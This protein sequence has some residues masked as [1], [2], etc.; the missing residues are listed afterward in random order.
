MDCISV[1]TLAKLMHRQDHPYVIIDCRFDYEFDAG[2]I[3]GA[4]NISDP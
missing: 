2:H 3:R 4:I 1:E